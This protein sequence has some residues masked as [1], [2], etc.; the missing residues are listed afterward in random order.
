MITQIVRFKS[1][2]S[3]KEVE[4]TYRARAPQYRAL[5][6]LIQKYYLSFPT[7][8]EHGAV[9]LW[10]SEEALKAFRASDLSRTIAS[11]YQVE[12]E[13][14]VRIG[15]IVMALRDEVKSASHS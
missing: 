7:S 9:Y 2:L 5:K 3:N 13:P 1:R 6:G 8:G 15:E 14:D 10:E 4:E 11:A 12:G